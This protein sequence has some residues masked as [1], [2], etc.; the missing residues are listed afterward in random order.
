MTFQRHSSNQEVYSGESSCGKSD[1]E[2]RFEALFEGHHG[3]RLQ[4][5]IL[6]DLSEDQVGGEA[7]YGVVEL[8]LP[9]L[10]GLSAHPIVWPV[11]VRLAMQSLE[12]LDHAKTLLQDR[13]VEQWVK[14]VAAHRQS[15][16]LS[17]NDSAV[18]L[19]GQVLYR[20]QR[21]GE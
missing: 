11:R 15:V 7:L 18:L 9:E 19:R 3:L 13:R 16:D 4:V 2:E 6:L 8:V 20:H 1:G 12:V 10:A 14:R 5:T 21:R 17:W